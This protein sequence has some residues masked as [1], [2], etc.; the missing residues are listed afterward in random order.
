MGLLGPIQELNR[1]RRVLPAVVRGGRAPG[2][3]LV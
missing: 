3:V 2:G 1:S